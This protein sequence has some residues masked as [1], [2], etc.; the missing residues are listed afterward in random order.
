MAEQHASS[1]LGGIS[2]P[3][4]STSNQVWLRCSE[5]EGTFA[6]SA[7]SAGRYRRDGREPVCRDCRR[8][9]LSE[10][11][12]AKLRRWWLKRFSDDELHELGRMI[13]PD[14]DSE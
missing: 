6:L 2:L 10:R 13:W 14:T 7:S 8:P 4:R 12:Q 5:C 9:K 11:Q 3:V 1:R